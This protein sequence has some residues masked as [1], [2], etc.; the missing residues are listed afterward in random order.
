MT[1]TTNDIF[2]IET[3]TEREDE[4]AKLLEFRFTNLMNL[5]DMRI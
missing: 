3:E 2:S 1:R 5:D 4:L